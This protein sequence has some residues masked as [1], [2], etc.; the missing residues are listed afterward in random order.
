M[1]ALPGVLV[2]VDGIV[3]FMNWVVEATGYAVITDAKL[4]RIGVEIDHDHR[5]IKINARLDN[6]GIRWAL[7]RSFRLITLGQE[8]APEFCTKPRLQIVPLVP[9]LNRF[10]PVLPDVD[11]EPACLRVADG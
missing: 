6:I 8:F 9:D 3:S 11:A 2:G 10:K 4:G 7:A 1:T 5:E